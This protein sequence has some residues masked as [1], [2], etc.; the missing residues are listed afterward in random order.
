[1][2]LDANAT[3]IALSIEGV[4]TDL[5]VLEFVGREALNQPYRFDVELVSTRPDL[6]LDT[7]INRSAYLCFGPAQGGVHGVIDRIEQG[8]SGHRLTRYSLTL[9][10]KLNYLRHCFDQRIYQHLSVPQ[11]IALVLE[12]HGILDGDYK[13]QLGYVYP[14]RDYCVQYDE[15]DLH[16]IQ[17]LCEEEG[18]SYHFQ[19]S[20]RGHVLVFG[21]DQTV[22][23]K[24]PPLAYQQ[25][26]GLSADNE[27]VRAFGVRLETQGA[28]QPDRRGHRP[29][30]ILP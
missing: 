26:T 6:D 23:P 7:L 25:D 30:Q 10:P 22:F 12:D 14:E 16:F 21:D 20:T 11:V 17:R 19:H 28:R 27:V 18:I 1:M 5:Q 29:E 15:S 9:R 24:L 3:Q 4:S 13:F 2:H 8:D